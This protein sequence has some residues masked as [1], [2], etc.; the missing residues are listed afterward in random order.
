[1]MNSKKELAAVGA[2][3]ALA[4]EGAFAAMD[5]SGIAS[6]GTDIA[7]VGAAVF[8]IFIAVKLVHWVRRAL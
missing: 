2:A 4:A 8:L 3:L 7:A 1:M 6:A 5:V